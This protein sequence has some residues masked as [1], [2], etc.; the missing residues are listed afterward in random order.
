MR[1]IGESQRV[2][3][4]CEFTDVTIKSI[5]VMAVD[6]VLFLKI[7]QDVVIEPL[8]YNVKHETDP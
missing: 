2:G 5:W 8:L 1:I 6:G 7:K 4:L 3:G